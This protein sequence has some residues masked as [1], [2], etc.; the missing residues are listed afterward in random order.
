MGRKRKL[1]YLN[2]KRRSRIRVVKLLLMGQIQPTACGIWL[3]IKNGLHLFKCLKKIKRGVFCDKWKLHEIKILVPI[4]KGLLEYTISH[5]PSCT[6]IY[7]FF[8]FKDFI[9]SWDTHREGQRHRQREKQASCG[10]P[11]VGLDPRTRGHGLGLGSTTEPPGCPHL[12]LFLCCN[13]RVE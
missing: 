2:L 12:W 1:K 5:A 4:N 9:Y 7:G 8:F 3:T 13:I 10:E 11:D 6:F